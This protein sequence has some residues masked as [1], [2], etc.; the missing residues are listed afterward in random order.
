MSKHEEILNYIEKLDIGKQVSVRSIAN[1]LKV[2]DGTAYR[3]IKEAENR[4]LVAVND[5]SGTVRV[6]VKGQ[7]RNHKLT[8]GKIAEIAS[9]EI[10]GGHAGLEVEFSRFSIGAMQPESVKKF[11]MKNSLMIVGDRKD[12]QSMALH[13]QSAVLVTGGFD[14]DQDVIDYANEMGIP[15]M[16]AT[17]DTFTVA[18]RIS[19]AL[20]N[21]SIKKDIITVA[22]ISHDHRPALREEDTVKDFME[23]M[24]RTNLSRFVVVNPHRVVVGVVSMRDIAHKSLDTQIN[25]LM[26]YPDV[27]KQKMTVASI[28][29]KMIH[30]GY[31][32]MPIVNKDY[33]YAG[34]VT[35]SEVL[36]SLQRSQE[37]SQVTHTFSEDMS[38]KISE[39]GSAYTVMVEPLMVNNVGNIS[40]AA[41]SEIV[42]IVVQRTL[43]KRRRRNVI[44]ESMNLNVMGTVAID[45]LLE[46]Y[47]KVINETRLGAVVDIE[48]YYVNN[49]IAKAV[50]NL[51]IT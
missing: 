19:H 47:P 42:A 10:L 24:K 25:K 17:Y 49:I 44:L 26:N 4:G 38:S 8:F 5:R 48:I 36:E 9:A 43:D 7:K 51:Q 2:A 31:D 18:N 27:A 28:S 33:T 30:E 6:S 35:K 46:I 21:E 12:I 3:A 1:R 20:A 45:N 15:L 39:K 34:V 14:I 32:I 50:V 29:Q 22:E 23:L 37:E 13:G 11:L 40:S 16:R 41:L